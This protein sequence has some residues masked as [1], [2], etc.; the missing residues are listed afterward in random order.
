MALAALR[1]EP[2]AAV[3]LLT[4]LP[5]ATRDRSGGDIDA[6]SAARTGAAAFGL[7]GAGLGL[8]GA[9]PAL[10]LG[11]TMPFLAA[12]LGIVAIAVATGVLH[13]DGLADTADAL[14]APDPDAAERARTDPRIGPAGAV[15][16]VGVLLIDV[17]A[18]AGTADLAGPTIAA[19]ALV[20]AASGSRAAAVVLAR[21]GTGAEPT[22]GT[23]GGAGFG[24]WFAARVGRWDVAAALGS[25]AVAAL[26]F[27][28]L[29]SVPASVAAV[30]GAAAGFGL[31]FA[32]VRI[33]GGLDGDGLGAGV[34][35]VFAATLV[36]VAIWSAVGAGS[37]VVVP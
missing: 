25:A 2:W 4:R 30:V 6:P 11:A 1:A 9:A 19:L 27:A 20:V 12:V 22:H 18:V 21:T 5:V 34:E 33:R 16:V 36:A 29:G 28:V 13:L 31:S 10:F 15:A 24:A 35:L 26:A 17:A 3:A 14:A 23:P 7:V 37:A 32:V 8:V